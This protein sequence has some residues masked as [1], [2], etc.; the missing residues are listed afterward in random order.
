ME[1]VVE[2]DMQGKVIWEWCF[3]DHVVQDVDA[4]KPK[5]V[6]QGKTVADHPSRININTLGRPLKRD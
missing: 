4:S 5:Y 3:F 1:A 6:G 2:V